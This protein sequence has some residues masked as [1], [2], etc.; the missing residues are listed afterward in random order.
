ML[1]KRTNPM[2]GRLSELLVSG[3]KTGGFLDAAI[4][5]PTPSPRSPVDYRIQSP[6]GLKNYDLGGVGLGIV[7]ALEKSGNGGHEILAKYAIF[8]PSYRSDPIPVKIHKEILDLDMDMDSLEEDYTYVTRHGDDNKSLT[9]VFYD[10]GGHNILFDSRIESSSSSARLVDEV[11][12]Y[13]TSDFLS[14]CYL[15]KKKLQG[16][17]IFMYR[18]EKAFCSM[19]CRSSQIIVDERKEQCRSEVQRSADVST[20][21]PIFSTGIL[22]I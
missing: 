12:L 8:S 10:H 13:P 20:A 6:R 19:E 2:I 7:A 18:G 21:S 3:N 22:A 1:S 11:S 16:R 4:S 15:C 5:T 9:K 14:S 17:D